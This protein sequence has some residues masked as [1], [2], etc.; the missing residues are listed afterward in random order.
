MKLDTGWVR[1]GHELHWD[2]EG[3]WIEHP[4][5]CPTKDVPLGP[6]S[7]QEH[8]CPAGIHEA[9]WGL[10]ISKDFSPEDQ[11]R[12]KDF[13]GAEPLEWR[14]YEHRYSQYETETRFELRLVPEPN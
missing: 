2:E 1:D 10:E 9:H 14:L 5:H 6:D 13:M 12:L 11:E 3:I 8:I 7:Y 4:D